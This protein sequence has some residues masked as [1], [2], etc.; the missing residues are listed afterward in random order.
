MPARAIMMKIDDEKLSAERLKSRKERKDAGVRPRVQMKL[1]H[2]NSPIAQ[3]QTMATQTAAM[4]P[5]MVR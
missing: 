4:Q 5:T 3:K 2:M 1:F